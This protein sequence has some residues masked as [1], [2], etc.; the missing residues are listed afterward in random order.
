VKLF[1]KSVLFVTLLVTA[2]IFSGCNESNSKRA[3]SGGETTPIHL[4]VMLDLDG[5][6]S[7]LGQ[8]AMNGFVLALQDGST[9]ETTRVYTSLI[10]TKTDHKITVEAAKAVIP[11]V[12]VAAG[13]TNN[14]SVLE[15]G[16]FFQDSEV[17]FLSI[18]A[19][20]PSL[21]IVIGNYIFLTPFGDNAQAAAAA[22]FAYKK[23]GRRVAIVW[24][25]TSEY[26]KMLPKYFRTRFEQLGG[27]VVLDTSFDGGCD[28]S[29]IGREI[30]NLGDQPIFIYL[31]GLPD[32]IGEVIAS[33][34][35]AGVDL[36]IVGGDGFDT[37]NLMKGGKKA[38]TDVW[39]TTHA[40]LSSE[41]GT[42]KAKAFRAAYERAYG[43]GPKDAFSALGFDAANL[44]LDVFRRVQ[45]IDPVSME[46]A[47]EQTKDFEGVTGTI[48]Y[49]EDNH[50]PT[51]TVWI[52]QV[53]DGKESLATS[54]IPKNVPMP[55]TPS[56]H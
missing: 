17:P 42:P 46:S 41:T 52:I 5:G 25:S 18:G 56:E 29:S 10:D 38:T 36:P 16:S 6:Q 43:V 30:K 20:D 34:R 39:Y 15:V 50:V 49:T 28:I 22:E 2:F 53:E 12:V 37:P 32:C 23:F 14:D 47:L 48:S 1:R 3:S 45:S 4:A 7:T 44:L 40:W 51:K 8:E 26:T 31:A 24:D 27:D 11:H 9:D 35:S 13:F 21:P 54:M 33:L 55:I 19:T